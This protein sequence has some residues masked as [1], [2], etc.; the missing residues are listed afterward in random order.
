MHSHVTM[1]QNPFDVKVE[2]MS[3]VTREDGIQDDR[4]TLSLRGRGGVPNNFYRERL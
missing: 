2:D 4:Y 1:E 3:L